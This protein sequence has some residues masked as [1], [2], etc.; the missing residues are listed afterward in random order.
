MYTLSKGLSIFQ[1]F[2]L[3]PFASA[4]YLE[5]WCPL[6]LTM[7]FH[8]EV[9][10][11]SIQIVVITSFVVISNAGI[12]RVDC[13]LRSKNLVCFLDIPKSSFDYLDGV[14]LTTS[15]RTSLICSF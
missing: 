2:A 11:R 8:L 15:P 5:G 3:I 7:P 9:R 14:N 1:M 4:I 12:K 10:I 13:S 6:K